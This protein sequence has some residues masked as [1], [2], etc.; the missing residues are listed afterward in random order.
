[1]KYIFLIFG[2]ILSCNSPRFEEKTIDV[3]LK[4]DSIIMIVD[5][6]LL[7]VEEEKKHKEQI[8]DS[9]KKELET[10]N[11][12]K[13]KLFNITEKQRIVKKIYFDTIT[14]QIDSSFKN[15]NKRRF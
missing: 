13:E 6:K 4:T 9:L 11:E 3:V 2:I 8:L 14:Y 10:K 5:D 7:E 15:E 1:M 12:L